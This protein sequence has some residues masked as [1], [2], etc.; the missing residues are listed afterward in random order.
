MSIGKAILPAAVGGLIVAG[1][2]YAAEADIRGLPDLHGDNPKDAQ[3]AFEP[4]F[5][6]AVYMRFGEGTD[7]YQFTAR[8]AYFASSGDSTKD[9]VVCAM[10]YLKNSG[11]PTTPAP[12]CQPLGKIRTDFDEFDFG[13]PMRIYAYVDN[14]NVAFNSKTPLSITPFGAFDEV[15]KG[16]ATKEKNKSFYNAQL[17]SL[18]NPNNVQGKSY[19]GLSFENHLKD[20]NGTAPKP[21]KRAAHSINFNLLACKGA[22][23]TCDFNNEKAVIPLVIDPDGGNMGGGSPPP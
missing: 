16:H 11:G 4:K 18:P 9:D 13:Q 8:H 5:F 15:K 7:G 20:G 14:G 22:V 19:T 21:G 6:A 2:F 12:A 17:M 23:A 10:D 1:I 3:G